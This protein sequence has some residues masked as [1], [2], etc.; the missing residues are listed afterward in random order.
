METY[1]Q[2]FH[3]DNTIMV[4]INDVLKFLP[5]VFYPIIINVLSLLVLYSTDR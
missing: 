3:R 2:L 1:L 4:S 5:S